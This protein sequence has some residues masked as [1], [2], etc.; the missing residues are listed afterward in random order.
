MGALP[1]AKKSLGQH[2]LHDGNIIRKIS[3]LLEIGPQD[4]VLEIGPG[5]GAL[6]ARLAEAAPRRLLCLE[7][8]RSL[9]P[10]VK[11][12]WPQADVLLM[13]ALAAPWERLGAALPGLKLAGNLPYN[14]A[15]P[16]M[17]D[18]LSRTPDYERAVFMMQKEVAL[19][20]CAPPG[21]KTYG[22]LSV[23]LQAHAA[24]R[25]AF[26]VGPTVFTPPPKVDSSVV[27]F[28]PRP[29]RPRGEAGRWL[30][31]TIK[32]A[33]QQRRKQLG[34]IFRPYLD[35]TIEEVMEHA[36]VS[37]QARPETLGVEAFLALSKWLGPRITP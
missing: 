31:A 7:K 25:L 9:A 13:D 23:W 35:A 37:P 21:G 22:A 3:A 27:V 32:L 26:S 18:C 12:R 34:T 28:L 30:A 5:T 15:S 1:R 8:D 29:E 11:R 20:V 17:W 33:F 4:A 24:P 10:T 14:V 36:A 2:F 16:L 19:R 6:T